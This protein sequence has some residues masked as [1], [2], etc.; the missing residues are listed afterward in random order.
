MVTGPVSPEE[1][2]DGRKIEE[3]GRNRIFLHSVHTLNFKKSSV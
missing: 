2:E 1:N 3:S